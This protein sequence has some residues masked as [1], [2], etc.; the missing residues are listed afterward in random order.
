MDMKEDWV[1][2]LRSWAKKKGYIRELWL[3]GSR[4]KGTS[5]PESDFHLAVDLMPY[6]RA[7][8]AY[9]TLHKKWKEELEAI[10]GHNVDFGAIEEGTKLEEEVKRTGKRLWGKDDEA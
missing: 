10:V 9:V 2:G 6:E 3:F 1:D 7:F 8:E 5:T 4:A